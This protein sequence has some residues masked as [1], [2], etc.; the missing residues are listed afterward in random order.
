MAKTVPTVARLK[1]WCVN[2][3]DVGLNLD[4]PRHRA[5]GLHK[6]LTSYISRST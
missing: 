2:G 4:A 3:S 5:R 6:D 1:F